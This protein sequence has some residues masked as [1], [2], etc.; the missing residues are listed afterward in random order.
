MSVIFRK[1]GLNKINFNSSNNKKIVFKPTP[2]ISLDPYSEY[3]SLLL[4]FDQGEFL[5]DSSINNFQLTAVGNVSV[6]T[7]NFKYGGGSAY[8]DGNGDYI[9]IPANSN[10]GA[11]GT[12]DFTIEWWEYIINYTNGYFPIIHYGAS[13]DTGNFS[14]VWG[15]RYENNGSFMRVSILG[16]LND[17]TELTTPLNT[18]RHCALVR[19]GS[20]LSLY[21][22]GIKHPTTRTSTQ[23]LTQGN[24][25]SIIGGAF[26]GGGNGTL[27]SANG[28]IDD[29]RIT[30]GIARYTENFTPPTSAFPNP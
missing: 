1:S 2:T 5:K 21:R 23:N 26:F 3:V 22:D 7:T 16:T 6:N 25:D 8:F 4:H 14:S 24:V 28:Y 27:Y 19:Q 29:L 10:F 30:K 17:F 9:T 18:W 15:I 20:S 13:G 12:S 11:F